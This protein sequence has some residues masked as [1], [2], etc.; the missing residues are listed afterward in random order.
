MNLLV[1]TDELPLTMRHP[2][3]ERLWRP[4]FFGKTLKRG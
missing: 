4:R 1:G 3:A 2:R